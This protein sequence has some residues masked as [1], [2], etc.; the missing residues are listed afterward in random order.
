V[1]HLASTLV[2]TPDRVCIARAVGSVRVTD[3][4]TLPM[5]DHTEHLSPVDTTT[6]P[7]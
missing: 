3:V 5:S 7:H 2:E 1:A 4:T 6:E